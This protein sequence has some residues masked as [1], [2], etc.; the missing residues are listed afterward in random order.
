MID[1]KVNGMMIKYMVKVIL[2]EKMVNII[3]ENGLK[4]KFMVKVHPYKLMA[5]YMMVNGI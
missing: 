2:Q 5:I 4:I 3:M 1:L